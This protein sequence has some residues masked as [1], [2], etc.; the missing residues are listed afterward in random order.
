MAFELDTSIP[1]SYKFGPDAGTRMAQSASIA[2]MLAQKDRTQQATAQADYE[3]QQKMQQDQDTQRKQQAVQSVFQKYS[4]PD[5]TVDKGA[6]PELYKIDPAFAGAFEKQQVENDYKRAYDAELTARAGDYLTKTA[7][8]KGDYIGAV[9][10]GIDPADP[11]VAIKYNDAVKHLQEG[12]LFPQNGSLDPE[13]TGPGSLAKAKVTIDAW[14][15][16]KTK[17]T[18]NKDAEAAKLA[19]D[20]FEWEKTHPKAGRL[21]GIL[22]AMSAE[23]NKALSNAIDNGLDPHWINSRTANI[24]AQQEMETPGRKWNTL[25]AAATFERSQST[26]NTNA[27][28]SAV[29]PLMDSLIEAGKKLN[30]TNVPGINKIG[31][32]F[33]EASGDPNIVQFNNQRDDVIAEVERGLLG[34]GV[35]SDSKYQR[36]LHNVNSAQ[37]PAQ[38]ESAVKAMKI[39]ISARLEAL[40]EKSGPGAKVG[41]GEP[42]IP[43]TQIKPTTTNMSDSDALDK[44]F[45]KK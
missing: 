27:L 2:N 18:Y 31:N 4:K 16:S 9:M 23:E 25:S 28:L 19:R 36:A 45:P 38:L 17:L 20:K 14:N 39:V 24:F 11:M 7:V 26:M 42:G 30:N 15:Q 3:Q 32:W 22:S 40:R 29:N 35:L 21:G 41:G 6:I 37:S 43:Q 13:W 5:G 34:T 33:K 10:S 1:Q 44:L 8:L 12:G